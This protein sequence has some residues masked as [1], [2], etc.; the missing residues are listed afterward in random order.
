VG[1]W[2]DMDDAMEKAAHMALTAL[3]SQNLAATACTPLWMYPIQD[4]SDLEWKSRMDE[5]GNVFQ[6]HYRSGWAYMA[7]YS[8]HLFQLQHDTHRIIVEQRCCL[9]GYAKEVKNLT[10]EIS[11]TA[12]E[13][14][15]VCQ[16][17]RDLESHLHDKEE[18]LLSSL[19]RSSERDQEL[20]W[21]CVLLR[22]VEEAAKVKAREFE[23]F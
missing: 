9:V 4:R 19:R 17:V 14:G 5:V 13:N 22:M 11:R 21:H 18:A 3:C 6:V 16:Q 7:G 2:A 12:Q 8:H 10:Q 23:E 15:V 1:Y 20:L